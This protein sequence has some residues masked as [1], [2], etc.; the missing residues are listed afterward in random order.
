MT[1]SVNF[2]RRAVA[3]GRVGLPEK[4]RK[5][6]CCRRGHFW[7]VY[8]GREGGDSDGLVGEGIGLL[9]EFGGDLGEKITSAL[10]G[11]VSTKCAMNGIL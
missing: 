3:D 11:D 9:G 5:M 1:G 8:V 2:T 7:Y 6:T 4:F 10:Y